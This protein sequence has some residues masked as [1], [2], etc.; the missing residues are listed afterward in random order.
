LVNSV[1]AA[2]DSST[3]STQGAKSRR[4]EHFIP[5]PRGELVD[6]FATELAGTSTDRLRLEH[7]CQLLASVIH[8]DFQLTCE[9]LKQAYLP[10]DPDSDTHSLREFEATEEQRDYEAICGRL[11][12]LLQR[13]NFR[14]LSRRDIDAALLA[15]NEWGV[16][17]RVDF[18]RFER[19]EVFARGDVTV[20]R[21]RRR[22]RRLFRTQSI[23]V[24]TYQR[25][26]VVFRLRSA[27]REQTADQASQPLFIKLFKDI[28]Q[29][30]IESL[31][32]GT[33]VRMTWF[34]RS[35]ILLPTL[36]GIGITVV[37]LLHGALALLF[38]GIYGVLAFLGIVGA[39][40][41]YGLRTFFGYLQTKNKYQLHLTRNLYYQNLDNNRG[42]ILRMI[43]EAE[44]QE[45]RE[46]ML[47]YFLL[48]RDAQPDGWTAEQLD[49]A[50]ESWLSERLG[51]PVDFEI[52]DALSKLERL[53]LAVRVSE[54][55]WRAIPFDEA[56]RQLAELWQA[57]ARL[58]TCEGASPDK[59][60]VPPA[61]FT[62]ARP[63]T[64]SPSATR[65]ARTSP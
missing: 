4:R 39:T 37:K 2:C 51:T 7:L 18:G 33:S 40:F 53:R 64:D 48:W 22:W 25:L 26:A 36:S 56:Y 23:D 15:M 21:R 65:G 28:P 1:A 3:Q 30:D 16:D 35:R 8:R 44:E 12:D 13:A 6:A 41:G 63:H 29:S 19:L 20:P 58:P 38:A 60:A 43:D 49:E 27:S 61:H 55:R 14:Q 42:A 5:V 9:S 32:P 10:F 57:A 24:P 59:S 34:D 52:P 11:Q 46:A 31:L 50:A 54:Q 45:F 17:L 47:A 62:R